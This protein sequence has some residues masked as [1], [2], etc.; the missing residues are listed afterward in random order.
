MGLQVHDIAKLDPHMV[1][2]N[3]P[4]VG[5]GYP[6]TILSI[7][8]Y[9]VS[10]RHSGSKEYAHLGVNGFLWSNPRCNSY[11]MTPVGMLLV[12]ALV[13]GMRLVFYACCVFVAH[14]SSPLQQA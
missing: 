5:P 11:N 3:R 4:H 8:P 1:V 7:E 6:L 10:H 13:N 14:F 9:L 12:R 2:V